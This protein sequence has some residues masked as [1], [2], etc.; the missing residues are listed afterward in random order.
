MQPVQSHGTD[1]IRSRIR[2]EGSIMD[3]KSFVGIDVSKDYFDVHVLPQ[4]IAFNVKAL[5]KDIAR[6]I[7]KL[8][9]LNVALIV[10]EATGG[11]GTDLAAV[12]QANDLPTAIVNPRQTRSFAAATGRL[13]KTDAIDANVLAEFAQ[14]IQPQARPVNDENTLQIKAL[15]ARR[16][17][18]IDIRTAEKNRLGHA[19][20][21]AVCKSI[22]DTIAFIER[23]IEDTNKLLR[24][25]V[26]ESSE[27]TQKAEIIKSVPGVGDATCFTLL[28]ELPEL[29]KLSNKQVAALVGV[30]PMNCDSGKF[31]GYRKIRGG[32]T[33]V[34][35]ALYMAALVATRYNPKIKAYYQRLVKNGKKKIVALV[36]SIR[37]L[38]VIL[39]T[40]LKEN[41]PWN[42]ALVA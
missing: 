6:C 5:D 15:V 8:K 28:T 17:Q 32:R 24:Q 2:K 20:G 18:L 40:M 39:N 35:N 27:W 3:T 19:R 7:E 12:L 23:Q 37:K 13:A 4:N 11:Y 38:L 33:T 36:A 1:Y 22:L 31:R 9:K 42:P 16:R 30:A 14:A 34:R 25:A 21:E 29:G 26:E 41:K 10:L